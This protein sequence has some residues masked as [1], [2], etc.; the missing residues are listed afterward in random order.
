MYSFSLVTKTLGALCEYSIAEGQ[1][2]RTYGKHKDLYIYP[3]LPSIIWSYLLW[4]PVLIQYEESGRIVAV[5][6][7]RRDIE[8]G[9]V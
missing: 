9:L 1:L 2:N 8:N 6:G 3:V 7:V 5:L 4:A